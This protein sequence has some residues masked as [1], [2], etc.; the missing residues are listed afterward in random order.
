[1]PGSLELSCPLPLPTRSIQVPSTRSI[2]MCSTSQLLPY[3]EQQVRARKHPSASQKSPT[4]PAPS[5]EVAQRRGPQ[6]PSQQHPTGTA[7]G[8]PALTPPGVL[9]SV[10]HTCPASSI[11]KRAPY[12]NTTPTALI[13]SATNCNVLRRVLPDRLH[14]AASC[15]SPATN[16][17]SQ[18]HSATS[19]KLRHRLKEA[20]RWAFCTNIALK[21]NKSLQ[22]Y[23]LP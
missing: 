23:H 17:N 14:R 6:A 2:H 3:T 20:H 15:F 18:K 7:S 11:F 4:Q 1:M 16:A 8:S 10:P 12:G 22:I 21:K 9:S 5:P 19:P 13:C